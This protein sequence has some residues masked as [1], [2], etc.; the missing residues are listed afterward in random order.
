MGFSTRRLIHL[1]NSK[2]WH[3]KK[4]LFL[5]CNFPYE[6]RAWPNFTWFYSRYHPIWIYSVR[7]ETYS[8]QKNGKINS[9]LECIATMGSCLHWFIEALHSHS[10]KGCTTWAGCWSFVEVLTNLGRWNATVG[11]DLKPNR[12]VQECWMGFMTEYLVVMF[13]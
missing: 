10:V 8:N 9:L 1:H 12:E 13:C 7:L 2:Y 4:S 3:K 6:I 5:R 11:L